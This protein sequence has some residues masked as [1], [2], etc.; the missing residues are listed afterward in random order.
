MEKHKPVFLKR[1]KQRTN[2]SLEDLV[3]SVRCSVPKVCA[4]YSE[5]INLSDS[6]LVK[7]KLRDAAFIIEFFHLSFITGGLLLDNAM[8]SQPEL[9]ATITHDLVLL[10]NQLPF[11]VI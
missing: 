11:F 9:Y 6:K 2:T 5:N 7:L 4:S 8:L 3:S 10:E 1:L